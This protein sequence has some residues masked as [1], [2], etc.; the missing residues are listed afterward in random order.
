MKKLLLFACAVTLLTSCTQD[1]IDNKQALQ[2][3]MENI[4][5]KIYAEIDDVTSRTY[6]EEGNHL[7]WNEGDKISYFPGITYNLEYRFDGKTGDNSGSFTKITEKL[8]TGNELINTYAFYPYNEATSMSDD[9]IINFTFPATQSYA[10]NSF[11]LGANAMVAVTDGKDD[12]ILRF[13]NLCGY[14]KLKVYGDATIKSLTLKGNDDEP[15]AGAATITAIYGNDPVTT[16]ADDATTTLIIDCGTGVTLGTTAEEATEFWFVV[17][18]YNFA[19]GISIDITDI[20][21]FVMTQSTTKEVIVNR[22]TIQPMTAFEFKPQ[23]SYKPTNNEILYTAT[24][25]IEP[26]A[27]DAFGANIISNEWNETTGE[28]TIT[29]DGDVY[30]LGGNAFRDLDNLT[31]I[32]I[33]NSIILIGYCAFYGCENLTTIT[34]P[35]ELKVIGDSAFT[36]CSKLTSINIPNSVTTIGAYAFSGCSIA[37]IFIPNSFISIGS[38]AFSGCKGTLCI[39]NS[40]IMNV[41]CYVDSFSHKLAYSGIFINSKFSEIIFGDNVSI[42]PQNAFR[43]CYYLKKITFGNNI[44]YIEDNAF[45]DCGLS[46]VNLPNSVIS[47]GDKAFYSCNSMTDIYIPNSVISIGSNAF[48]DCNNLSNVHINDIAKWCEIKFNS[49]DSNPLYYADNLYVNGQL[50]EGVLKLDKINEIGQYAFYEYEHISSISLPDTVTHIGSYAFKGCDNL[51]SINLGNG[52]KIIYK[53]AFS[54]CRNLTD[55]H[56]CD[57][58]VMINDY[59][60]DCCSSLTKISIPNSITTIGE[61]AFSNCS[62]LSEVFCKA[63]TP[64]SIGSIAFSYNASGRKIYVPASDDDS[65]IN[66]YKSAWSG[67][68]SSIY[69][70]EF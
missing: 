45:Y 8:I 68:K 7:R 33:P 41:T 39:D 22:N 53:Y 40:N 13:K 24:S 15:L 44:K 48:G 66:A 5:D 43:E 1:A 60:F 12:N 28:G 57:G 50:I 34:I 59:A 14:I 19:K 65:I 2:T 55:I 38:Y 54:T 32:T 52:L 21:G 70:Y 9:G 10:E 16:L 37:T 27:T 62:S 18:S 11:G 25:K 4:P 63:T 3:L 29:F 49:S 36:G 61:G 58:I 67:F 23:S 47:I 6:V 30:Y 56:L 51:S 31:N 42:I 64:P 17:P 69:E 26:Y 20:N 35:S 46:T